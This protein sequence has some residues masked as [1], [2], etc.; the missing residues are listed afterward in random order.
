MVTSSVTTSPLQDDGIVGMSSSN[1]DHLPDALNGAGLDC[2]MLAC[3]NFF[4]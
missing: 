3:L 4:S 1:V 2:D